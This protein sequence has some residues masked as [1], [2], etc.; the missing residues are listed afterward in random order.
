M[1]TRIVP[2]STLGAH[3]ASQLKSPDV[4]R[5]ANSDSRTLEPNLMPRTILSFRYPG[6]WRAGDSPL[7]VQAREFRTSQKHHREFLGANQHF[8]THCTY[9]ELSE[10]V[11]L[12]ISSRNIK[13]TE[14][15]IPL[16]YSTLNLPTQTQSPQTP[17]PKLQTP[18]ASQ[19]SHLLLLLPLQQPMTLTPPLLPLTSLTSATSPPPPPPRSPPSSSSPLYSTSPTP[20]S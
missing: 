13:S 7:A 10:K 8:W 12:R 20:N 18:P 9:T 14:S 2:P 1:D 6:S 4:G 5:P 17:N 15:C 16:H 3:E 19:P 11:E